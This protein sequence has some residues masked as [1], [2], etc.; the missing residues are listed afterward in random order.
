MNGHPRHEVELVV[1]V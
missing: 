1:V